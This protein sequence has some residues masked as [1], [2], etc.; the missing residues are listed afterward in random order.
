MPPD[1]WV[2]DIDRFKHS[3]YVRA[4]DACSGV[5]GSIREN[6][7]SLAHDRETSVSL[8]ICFTLVSLRHHRFFRP[9][10]PDLSIKK[11][12]SFFPPLI[13]ATSQRGRAPRPAHVSPFGP[14]Y[15]GLI[16]LPFNALLP[17]RRA[18]LS[19]PSKAILSN[20]F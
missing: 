17:P 7:N 1:A 11:F 4:P 18:T 13:A 5:T 3:P 12:S 9:L 14:R 20:C 2:A 16:F 19:P 8:A 10:R 15:F 6:D